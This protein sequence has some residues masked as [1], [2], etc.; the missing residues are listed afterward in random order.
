MWGY[1]QDFAEGLLE[2]GRFL[3]SVVFLFVLFVLFPWFLSVFVVVVFPF[4]LD[5]FCFVHVFFR[6]V[7]HFIRNGETPN[8]RTMAKGV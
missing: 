8:Q 4:F 2:R 1:Y 5:S 6:F 3:F 7:L